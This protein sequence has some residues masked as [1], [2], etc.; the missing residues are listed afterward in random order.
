MPAVVVD[1]S[2][3]S[4]P[5]FL[6]AEK[7]QCQ[8]CAIECTLVQESMHRQLC[9]DCVEH[10]YAGSTAR[11]CRHRRAECTIGQNHGLDR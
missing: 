2:S 9:V 6:Q 5:Q 7:V 11:K 8:N 3:G 10:R 4:R 1:C